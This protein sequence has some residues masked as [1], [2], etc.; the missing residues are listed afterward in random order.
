M[1]EQEER[2]IH[3]VACVEDLN[4]AWRILQDIKNNKDRSVFIGWAFELALIVYSKPYKVSIGTLLDSKNKPV[5]YKL[6]ERFIPSNYLDLH[7][8][9]IKSRDQIH[10][11]SDLNIRDAKAYI[12]STQSGKVVGLLQNKIDVTQEFPN[13]DLIIELIEQTLDKMYLEV[14]HL[15]SVLHFNT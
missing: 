15:K 5:K 13:I 10:A 3:F 7:N 8:R 6:D 9:I 11:H 12:T 4:K 1:T 2:Y 14:E